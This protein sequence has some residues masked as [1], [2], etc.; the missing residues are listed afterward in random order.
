LILFGCLLQGAHL[1]LALR[2]VDH[3]VIW[4]IWD[5][6]GLGRSRVRVEVIF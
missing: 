3:L 2:Y 6:L 1:V 5:L 4:S